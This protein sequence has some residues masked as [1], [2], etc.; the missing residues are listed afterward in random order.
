MQ[1]P[2]LYWDGQ[3]LAASKRL[4]APLALLPETHRTRARALAAALALVVFA[5]YSLYSWFQ[6]RHFV[7]PSWDLGI[8]AQLA[9]AYATGQA[10]IVHIKGEG[11][12]LLGDHFHPITLLLTPF[13]YVWPS[14]ATLLYVQNALIAL[15][16]YLLVRFAQQVLP[17]VSALCLGAAY[18]LSFGVQQAVSVQFHEVAFALPLLVMSLGYLVISR[19]T[20]QPAK[21]LRRA[22][23]WA[24]PLVFV[25]E[26]IGITVTAIGLVALLRTGWLR[27]ATDLVFPSA[28]KDPATARQRLRTALSSWVSTP[29]VAE[30]SV[31]A[32]WGVTW[33]LLAVGLILPYFNTGGIFDYSDKLDVGAAIGN[34]L[35]ALA[36]F[37]YPWQKSA[38]LGLILLVGVLAWV[39][40]PLALIAL[41][42]LLWRFLSPQEGYWLSTWHYSLVLMPIVFLALLDVCARPQRTKCRATGRGA[43]FR[44]SYRRLAPQILPALALVVAVALTPQQ[45]LWQLTDP[46]FATSQLS[47]SDTAKYNVLAS[48]PAGTTVAADLSVLTYL[49]EPNTVY[50]IGHE[51]KPAPDYVV[52]DRLGSAWNGKAPTDIAAYA[53][54]RYQAT[55]L[56]H[57]SVGTIDV[58]RK[59]SD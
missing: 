11:F 41:P 4:M 30:T 8:F 16:V 51:G 29:A 58:V 10:P 14:P 12:N 54:E 48:I 28:S 23:Y 37:F 3:I 59:I 20:D 2:P 13:Y 17:T 53:S 5:L 9:K 56:P 21:A 44:R 40:S 26:D 49:V 42:T 31:L 52:I 22:V 32:L 57:H 33:S 45:P 38:S 50:W 24:A 15:S 39:A 19:V 25:K 7:I 35:G 43:R 47:A 34:P 46:S 55:Y 36:Q 1:K 27:Q 18:A 6:W